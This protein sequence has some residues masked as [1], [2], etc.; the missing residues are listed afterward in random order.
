MIAL[1]ASWPTLP[2]ASWHFDSHAA[3]ELQ[4]TPPFPTSRNQKCA[5]GVRSRPSLRRML[6][7]ENA[8]AL[9]FLTNWRGRCEPLKCRAVLPAGAA[10]CLMPLPAP[11]T[12]GSSEAAPSSLQYF[13]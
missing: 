3:R 11:T 2:T 1:L 4:T 5:G 6:E 9:S 10:R 12:A 8:N 13:A 7:G